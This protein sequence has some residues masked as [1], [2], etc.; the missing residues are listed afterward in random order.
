MLLLT[1]PS[2]Y[3]FRFAQRQV[4]YANVASPPLLKG[5]ALSKITLSGIYA[6]TKALLLGEL[7]ACTPERSKAAKHRTRSLGRGRATPSLFLTNPSKIVRL[8]GGFNRIPLP[9]QYLAAPLRMT[10][11]EGV[12]FIFKVFRT[13]NL[14]SKY[15]RTVPTDLCDICYFGCRGDQWSSVIYKGTLR[16]ERTCN[17]RPYK[18]DCCLY[19]C[20]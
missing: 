5:E 13:V 18:F 19:I 6:N 14:R 9:Y 16:F 3:L 11:S 15:G 10:C 7:A 8:R 2:A 12:R 4:C 20:L 17:A 1:S